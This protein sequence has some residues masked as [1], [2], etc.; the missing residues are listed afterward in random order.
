MSLVITVSCDIANDIGDD[1]SRMQGIRCQIASFF[2][3]WHQTCVILWGCE[4]AISGKAADCIPENAW[5]TRL[6]GEY[7]LISNVHMQWTAGTCKFG[8]GRKKKKPA[9][10]TTLMHVTKTNKHK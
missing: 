8:V 6:R 3:K 2:L 5:T 9:T 7:W 10:Y 1:Y 4:Y